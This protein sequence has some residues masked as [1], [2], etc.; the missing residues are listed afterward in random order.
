MNA[1]LSRL[2]AQR[3]EQITFV[4]QLLNRVDAEERDLVDAEQ[5]NLT[6]AR[7]RIEQLDQ[8]IEPLREFEDLRAASGDG[9]RAAF[10]A[11]RPA[12]GAVTNARPLGAGVG[13]AAAPFM[14]R[15][16]GQFLVDLV[17]SRDMPNHPADPTAAARVA[18]ARRQLAVLGNQIT[19]EV[20]GVLPTPV[21]GPIVSTMDASRP[22]ITSLGARNLATIAGTGFTRPKI[23]QHT[24]AGPQTAEKTELP[25]R[26]MKIESVPFTKGTFGGAVNVSRQTIDWTSP[27]AWDALVTDLAAV[28]GTETEAAVAAAFAAGI[29]QTVGADAGTLEGWAVALYEAAVKAYLGGAA[30]GETPNGR[31]PDHVWVSLDMWASMGAIVDTAR[32]VLPAN[33]LGG[34][35]NNDGGVTSFAGDLLNAPRTVVPTL[36]SGTIIVGSSDFFEFYEDQIGLLSAVEPARLGVEVAY[37]GYTAYG[38][39]EPLCFC[40]V[41][42]PPVTPLTTTARTRS[43]ANA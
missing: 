5:A 25:S 17:A 43:N 19:T 3:A 10:G 35:G 31:L 15:S 4:D 39:V 6:A 24:T 40:K 23:T 42:A 8:Q 34:I 41:T 7:Q 33:A 14:Y 13:G 27:A 30:M 2:E 16:A 26:V 32:L 1:V 37:G 11:D 22:L 28:Y 38:F 12:G 20:P 29:T 21:V 18:E 9:A 36:P